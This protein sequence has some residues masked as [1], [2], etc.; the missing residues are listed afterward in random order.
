ME[1]PSPPRANTYMHESYCHSLGKEIARQSAAFKNRVQF[2]DVKRLSPVTG[3]V[4][5]GIRRGRRQNVG[6]LS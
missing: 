3:L 2:V 5:A 1:T 6:A 4:G